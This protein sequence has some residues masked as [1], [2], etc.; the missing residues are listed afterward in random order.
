MSGTDVEGDPGITD[1]HASPSADN[2]PAGRWENR[3]RLER[4]L[5]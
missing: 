5:W 4:C 2:I 1:H 3:A